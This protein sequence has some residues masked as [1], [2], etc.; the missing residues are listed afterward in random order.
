[1]LVYRAE[2]S[3]PSVEA[4][5]ATPRYAAGLDEASVLES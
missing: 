3:L 2:T 1:M 4:A 5:V